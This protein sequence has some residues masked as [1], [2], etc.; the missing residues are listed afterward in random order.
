MPQHNR[1]CHAIIINSSII[2][3]SSSQ[4]SPSLVNDCSRFLQNLAQCRTCIPGWCRFFR[5][6]A[7]VQSRPSPPDGRH[8]LMGT[9]P[10]LCRRAWIRPCPCRIR[11]YKTLR[12]C[13][14]QSAKSSPNIFLEQCWRLGRARINTKPADRSVFFFFFLCRNGHFCTSR[15]CLTANINPTSMDLGDRSISPAYPRKQNPP[16]SPPPLLLKLFSER[17]SAPVLRNRAKLRAEGVSTAM[18]DW[19]FRERFVRQHSNADISK[20]CSLPGCPINRN[21]EAL[22]LCCTSRET[23]RAMA[24]LSAL[25]IDLLSVRAGG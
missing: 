13:H 18:L 6:F 23:L 12:S 4:S 22:K 7:E 15:A 11:D 19:K 2:I 24:T 9:L 10:A 21:P 20:S 25:A 8:S 5:S 14:N 3:S 16:S 1:L 17:G